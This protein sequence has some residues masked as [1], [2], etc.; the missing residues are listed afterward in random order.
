[1]GKHDKWG[2]EEF[3]GKFWTG[4]TQRKPSKAT[5]TQ[6]EIKEEKRKIKDLEETARD[7]KFKRD[8]LKQKYHQTATHL[9]Q[10]CF[11]KSQFGSLERGEGKSQSFW[12]EY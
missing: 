8:L 2:Q 4:Q 6:K 5:N 12:F 11:Q 7:W 9:D 3:R 1:M 10:A